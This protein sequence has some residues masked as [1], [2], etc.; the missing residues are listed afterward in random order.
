M[1]LSSETSCQPQAPKLFIS[2]EDSMASFHH[3]ASLFLLY[4]G[5]AL[6]GSFI[7]YLRPD[8]CY[9]CGFLA[10]S[11]KMYSGKSFDLAILSFVCLVFDTRS[12]YSSGYPGTHWVDQ[13]NLEL[14][15]ILLLLSSYVLGLKVCAT[16][17][18]L[19]LFC[20]RQSIKV[21]SGLKLQILWLLSSSCWS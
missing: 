5:L 4:T 17:P 14:L 8:S 15:E 7:Q 3:L 6:S 20:L 11:W 2:M 18:G 21:Y 13:A 10:W 19:V 16:P 12:L 9:L 1:L